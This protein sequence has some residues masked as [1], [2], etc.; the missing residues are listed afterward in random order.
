MVETAAYEETGR[1]GE[2]E[3]R[4]YPSLMVATVT[5]YAENEAFGFLF[6]YI[7]GRN[8]TKQKMAM[9]APV[10]T[11]EK[12]EMTAP[13]VS[14]ATSMAFVLPSRFS[15]DTSPEPLDAQVHIQ[16]FPA[17]EVAVLRF[18]GYADEASVA[19]ITTRLLSNLG[20]E[21]IT[22]LGSPFLM[23]YN[24]P[25]TPGFLRRNEMGVEIQR[26]PSR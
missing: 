4:K 10:I 25:W 7:S 21:G 15:R 9:T 11:S 2:I 22:V 24:S 18:K 19:E 13:V 12:I 5:G 6:R 14:D 1:I 17:R 20:R 23:R 26:K 8:R 16:E 3:L